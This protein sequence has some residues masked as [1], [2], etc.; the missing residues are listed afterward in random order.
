M[1]EAFATYAEDVTDH[2][3]PPV[4]PL[5]RLP[6]PVDAS[7]ESYRHDMAGYY[8]TT[9]AKGAAALLAARAAAG[10][11]PWDQA[12]RCYVAA[13]AWRIATPADLARSLRSLPAA[14]AVLR[15]AGAIRP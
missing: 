3:A 6:G 14:L 8:R 2:G 10:A 12:L 13:N 11:G 1:D 7:T 9:Y 4:R 5:L 15:H